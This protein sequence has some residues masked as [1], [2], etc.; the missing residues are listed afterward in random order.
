MSASSFRFRK[1]PA[2]Y[3]G[4][5]MPLILSVFMTCIVSFISTVRGIGLADN[6]LQV[7]LG[8]W[9]VSWLLAFP[10][11]LLVLPVVRRLTG[12]LVEPAA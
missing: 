6:L 1:F 10:A 3:A 12:L 7:W 11:L 9:G 8:A 2:R 5:I 4:I